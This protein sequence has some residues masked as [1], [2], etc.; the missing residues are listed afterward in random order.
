MVLFSTSSTLRKL[1]P[2]AAAIECP[3]GKNSFFNLLTAKGCIYQTILGSSE[4]KIEVKPKRKIKALM[5]LG[6]L[7]LHFFVNQK[8]KW[9]PA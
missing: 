2:W 5:Q 3:L 8:P 6:W 4:D 9:Q 1:L 7:L